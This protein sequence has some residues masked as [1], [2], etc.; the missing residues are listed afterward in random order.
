MLESLVA[1]RTWSVFCISSHAH[2][3]SNTAHRPLPLLLLLLRRSLPT[4]NNTTPFDTIS[5]P[6]LNTPYTTRRTLVCRRSDY[7]VSREHFER[8][9]GTISSCAAELATHWN[10][11]YCDS[12]QM[13][14]PISVSNLGS[15]SFEYRKSDWR[16]AYTRFGGVRGSGLTL[17]VF[18]T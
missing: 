4:R 14:Y 15:E 6:S 8:I 10:G 5:I 18:S 7:K 13:N 2:Q 11:R 16:V 3:T 9:S 12:L 1:I 17:Q